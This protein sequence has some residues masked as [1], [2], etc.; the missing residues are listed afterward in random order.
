M[1]CSEDSEHW[2]RDYFSYSRNVLLYPYNKRIISPH[3][4]FIKYTLK[5]TLTTGLHTCP[6][7]TAVS[8][9]EKLH[10]PPLNTFNLKKAD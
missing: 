5:R 9:S 10:C 2:K 6:P 7:L 1:L 4:D 8:L 3:I